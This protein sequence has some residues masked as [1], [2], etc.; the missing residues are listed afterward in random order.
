M[1]ELRKAETDAKERHKGQYKK[2][3][4][5]QEVADTVEKELEKLN[6][7]YVVQTDKANAFQTKYE[8]LKTVLDHHTCDVCKA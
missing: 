7:K 8:R 6:A 3:E 1:G 5:Q 2:I 4:D